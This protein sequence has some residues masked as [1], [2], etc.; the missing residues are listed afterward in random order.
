[1]IG[2][3]RVRNDLVRNYRVKSDRVRNDRD[4]ID[5]VRSNWVRN[6]SGLEM[7]GSRL[8]RFKTISCILLRLK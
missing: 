1:M 3:N 7:I 2:L 8:I 5:R 4:R 6:D